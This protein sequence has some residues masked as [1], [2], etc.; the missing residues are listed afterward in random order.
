M[1]RG[2]TVIPYLIDLHRGTTPSDIE[3]YPEYELYDDHQTALSAQGI[4]ALHLT[5]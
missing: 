4:V 5:L 3:P 2:M 1:L